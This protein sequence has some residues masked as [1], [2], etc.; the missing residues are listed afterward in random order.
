ML[1]SPRF[2]IV[3]ERT[4]LLRSRILDGHFYQLFFN[5][6]YTVRMISQSILLYQCRNWFESGGG[7][8][9]SVSSTL[10]LGEKYR[11]RMRELEILEAG[12][13]GVVPP[14]KRKGKPFK[15]AGLPCSPEFRKALAAVPG[16][17][18]VYI[19]T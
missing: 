3:K 1:S 8:F 6:S 12:I 14:P 19:K 4:D 18:H 5:P 10:K 15:L 9:G 7:S 13:G 17:F 11:D 2:C 16:K